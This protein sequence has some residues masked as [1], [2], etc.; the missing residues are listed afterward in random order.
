[1][2]NPQSF[3][4]DAPMYPP[5]PKPSWWFATCRDVRSM[6]AIEGKPD[7]FCSLKQFSGYD[8]GPDFGLQNRLHHG[9]DAC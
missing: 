8:P 9:L 1:M 4:P 6:S 7:S 2:P 3:V 5:E